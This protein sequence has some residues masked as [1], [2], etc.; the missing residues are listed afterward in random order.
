M[1]IGLFNG[2]EFEYDR[3][4][5]DFENIFFDENDI[6][7]VISM[8]GNITKLFS[9][10]IKRGKRKGEEMMTI[11]PHRMFF[12]ELNEEKIAL[13]L[14]QYG[15]ELIS[16]KNEIIYFDYKDNLSKVKY[17]GDADVLRNK[18]LCVFNYN[19]KRKKEDYNKSN[20]QVVLVKLGRP[21]IEDVQHFDDFEQAGKALGITE[22]QAKDA[23]EKRKQVKDYT[24]MSVGYREGDAFYDNGVC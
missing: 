19:S 22:E 15:A 4:F 18:L 13:G 7:S 24:I 20:R 9:S 14:K 1:P 5:E 8:R 12:S 11:R 6:L 17:T 3:M 2:H 23:C 10:G 16:I 21:T